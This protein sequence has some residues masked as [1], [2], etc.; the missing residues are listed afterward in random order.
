MVAFLKKK[1]YSLTSLVQKA[2]RMTVA[3]NIFTVLTIVLI[4]LTSGYSATEFSFSN[5]L[6]AV[7]YISL[8]LCCF[9]LF[10]LNL[11]FS[12]INKTKL[13]DTIKKHLNLKNILVGLVI[14][15]LLISIILT[16][17]K[18][19][20]FNG[21]VR[22]TLV[23]LSSLLLVFTISFEKFCKLFCWS[24]FIVCLISLSVFAVASVLGASGGT[25]LDYTSRNAGIINYGYLSFFIVESGSPNSVLLRLCG[26]FWE[27]S[28]FAALLI[29][30]FILLILSDLKN[31]LPLYIVYAV[32]LFFTFSTGGFLMIIFV[33]LMLISEKLA[34]PLKRIIIVGTLAAIFIGLIILAVGP[35]LPF[36]VKTF[37]VVFG[38]MR[39]GAFTNVR[40]YSFSYLCKAFVKSPIIG[41]GINGA[42][43]EYLSLFGDAYDHSLTSTTGL[44]LASFGII[45]GVVAFLTIILPVL[46]ER[47]NNTTLVI[48]AA[49]IF[50]LVNLENMLMISAISL[51][52]IFL[53][54]EAL[55]GKQCLE[56]A[57]ENKSRVIDYLI[58]QSET[59]KT[60]KNLA[61]LFVIKGLSLIVALF[62]IPIYNTYFITN[63][64]YGIWSVIISVL[65]WSLLPT[66]CI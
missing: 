49:G 44:L 30:A 1:F 62:A 48:L 28:I 57:T 46:N 31:K 52:I 64:A 32:A 33:F 22:F 66:I 20:N 65:T 7:F 51:F 56:Y 18:N 29:V 15:L 3:K 23:F 25:G 60:N 47:Y 59:G 17:F 55:Y 40:F 10:V 4:I 9:I 38:K 50:V 36:L 43:L 24:M 6:V 19:N 5:R 27:P 16:S 21:A 13:I 58:G 34:N 61:G 35:M 63:E 42:R 45:G 26:P 12:K 2:D 8:F 41:H 53:N 14:F 11:P 39:N 54:K 37:P